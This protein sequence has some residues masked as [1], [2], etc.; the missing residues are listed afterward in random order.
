MHKWGDAAVRGGRSGAACWAKT[1]AYRC[2]GTPADT[3]LH[4]SM[5]KDLTAFVCF[6][7]V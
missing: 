6:E 2:F 5:S 4:D 3:L 7:D 1:A